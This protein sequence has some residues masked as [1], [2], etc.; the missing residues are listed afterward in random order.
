MVQD[1]SSVWRAQSRRE[2][3][4]A[5]ALAAA[6]VTFPYVGNVLGANDR[7]NVACIGVG[8]KGDSDTDD[9]AGCGANIVALCDVDENTLTR[10]AQKFPTAKRYRDFRK[11]LEEMDKSI[12]A[13]TVSTPDH[14]H[15]IASGMAMKLGKHVFCQKPLTQTV[16]E[17]RLIR[18]LARE[19]KVATQMG[20][21]G[22]AGSGLRR[23]VEVVQ[24]GV[25]GPVRE[26]HVWS[27]RPIWP[28]GLERPQREDR[29][30]ANLDW[31]LWIGPA[32]MRPFS[33]GTYHTFNW[34]GWCDFGTGA[35]GD[36]ACHTVNM[37]FRALKLGYPNI[38]ECE[39]ASQL[40]KETYPKTSRLRFEFPQREDMAPLKFWWYDGNPSD[41]VVKPFR[42]PPEVT[43]EIVNTREKVPDSGCVLIGDKGKLFSPDDAGADSFLLLKDEKE[44][45]SI[46]QHAAAKDVAETIPRSP[47]HNEEWFRMMRN[48]TPAYS[49]FDIAAYLTEI[50]LL[51]CIATRVGIGRR[52]EWDGPNMKSP[53]C[54]EAA[55][56][57]RRQNRPGWAV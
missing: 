4:R 21:Q 53:N 52:M 8:G 33:A 24:A 20:N 35:L 49:N 34:R 7:V 17:A 47:G 48:G 26:L 55:Q 12:D 28:Q 15:A 30:P 14:C 54:P 37:P 13:V 40:F 27:N 46:N 25:L 23:A 16:Y 57:V 45:L 31:D 42:P 29:V 50:I 10:K 41:K 11:L 43:K 5:S 9:T 32:P 3:L 18:Q 6:A 36:M 39:D 2:F 56:F 44:Y 38:V 1:N 19:K 51:G 22:S